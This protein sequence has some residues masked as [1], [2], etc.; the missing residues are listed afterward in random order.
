M[1]LLL[2]ENFFKSNF[3]I[4]TDTAITLLKH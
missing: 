2:F 4:E 3:M 1:F